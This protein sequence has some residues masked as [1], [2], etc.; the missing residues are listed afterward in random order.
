MKKTFVL[1]VAI[2][3]I[4]SLTVFTIITINAGKKYDIVN[5]N[6]DVIKQSDM[7][8]ALASSA[9]LLRDDHDTVL[10]TVNGEQ[11]TAYNVNLE[12]TILT[13][14]DYE[15]IYSEE[16]VIRMLVRDA[17]IK[18]KAKELG[19]VYSESE[20]DNRAEED[21]DADKSEILNE[22]DEYYISF[23]GL[24]RNEYIEMKNTAYE[25]SMTM[26]R[27]YELI[28]D[29][30]AAGKLGLN[31]EEAKELYERLEEAK[32]IKGNSKPYSECLSELKDLYIEK[33]VDE[34]E[35]VIYEDKLN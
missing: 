13:F 18:Q 29:D 35:V 27:F 8:R 22:S 15:E 1:V 20:K 2:V 21:L 9:K 19:Y 26:T 16:D 6:G 11:I 5:A 30:L 32:N 23:S 3:L 7:T 31:S 28:I 14:N 17:V 12:R 33:L 25:K 24:D 4:I 10:A 34:A